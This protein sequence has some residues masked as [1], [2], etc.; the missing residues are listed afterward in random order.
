MPITHVSS[1]EHFSDLIN[2]KQHDFV[3]VDFYA[4]WCGPCKRIAPELEKLSKEFKSVL[5]V[6]VNVDELGSLSH[7]YGVSAMP[8]FLVFKSG[9]P[10]SEYKPV[11]G[12]DKEKI[13]NLLKTVTNTVVVTEDF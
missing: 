10:D 8:T 11:V 4:D 3:F 13:K 9:N 2:T 6:K 5:F 1:E 12:A 7:R